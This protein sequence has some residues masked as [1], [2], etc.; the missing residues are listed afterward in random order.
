MSN[1][2]S[3]P[4]HVIIQQALQHISRMVLSQWARE[5]Q[6]EAEVDSQMCL[7]I[8]ETYS[9][10]SIILLLEFTSAAR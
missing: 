4:L 3:N 6:I 9:P 5:S 1:L 7:R 2:N 10:F 8:Q